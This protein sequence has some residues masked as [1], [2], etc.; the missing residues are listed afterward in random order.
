MNVIVFDIGGTLMEYVN[1]PNVWMDYYDSAFRHVR[2]KLSLP[3]TDEQ[4]AKS[5]EVL[6]EY[7]PRVKYREKDYP[8]EQIFGD[9]AKGWDFPYSQEDVISAFFEDMKLTPLIYPE[10]IPTLEKL[11]SAGWKTATLT[12]VATGMPDSLHKSYFPELMPYFD[13]YVSSQSCGFRKPNPAGVHYIARHFGAD[14]REFIFVG[15]EPKDIQ[16]AK[17]VGCRSVLIDR[18]NRGLNEGQDYTI[19]TLDELLIFQFV[20]RNS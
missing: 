19:K 10:T 7:N 13:L 15:D 18:K 1:M 6:R 5:I 14:E 20:I 4:L 2:E 3:L 12:D 8:P 16:T 9:A 11:R 17:N